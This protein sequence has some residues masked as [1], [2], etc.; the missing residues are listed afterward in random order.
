MYEN[1]LRFMK[2]CDILIMLIILDS[3]GDTKCLEIQELN[4][5]VDILLE[6]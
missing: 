4:P 3:E 1:A 5:D 2:K 6:R